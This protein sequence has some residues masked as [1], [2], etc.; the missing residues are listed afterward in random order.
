[1]NEY[2]NEEKRKHGK[3]ACDFYNKYMASSS[4]TPLQ[5]DDLEDDMPEDSP[6]RVSPL[7]AWQIEQCKHMTRKA[8]SARLGFNI[9]G[10][11]RTA[12]PRFFGIA[13][14]VLILFGVG[15][16]LTWLDLQP[17]PQH[18]LQQL[19]HCVTD[20]TITLPDGT[21][22]DLQAGSSLSIADDFGRSSRVVALSGQAFFDVATDSARLFTVEAGQLHAVVH[23]TSFNVLAHPG[24]AISEITVSSGCVEVKKAHG[25]HSFGRYRHGDQITYDASTGRESVGKVDVG[26]MTEWRSHEF[27]L[28]DA[29]LPQFREK[30]RRY[31]GVEVTVAQGAISPSARIN[32]SVTTTRPTV[33]NVM[34]AVC[35]IFGASYR[36]QGSRVII[37]PANNI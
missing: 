24:Q 20:T 12:R 22:V 18:R 23:G 33:G 34:E 32:C 14:A 37:Y 30:M 1:M 11:P 3:E 9:V 19:A 8:L 2:M 17:V 31:F 13:A 36:Q 16:M 4:D 27:H 35:T 7:K 21:R 26:D 15:I 6:T 28:T 25:G 5:A 29:T 10:S